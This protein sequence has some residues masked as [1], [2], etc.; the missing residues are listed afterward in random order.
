VAFGENGQTFVEFETD[1]F[2]MFSI[3]IPVGTFFINNNDFS[4][5]FTGV[6]LNINVPG[7]SYMRF[8]ST[9]GELDLALWTGYAT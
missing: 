4:T 8:G 1:H 9:T 6:I 5:S 2:T 7:A 3:G